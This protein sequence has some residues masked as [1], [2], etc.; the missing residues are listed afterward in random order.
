MTSMNCVVSEGD[1]VML[2][3]NEGR[4]YVV[5]VVRGNILSFNEGIVKVDDLLGKRYGETLYT[6]LGVRF[7]ITKPAILDVVYRKFTRRTQVVYPKD[8]AFI[9]LKTGVGPGSRVVEAGT[10]SGYLTAVLAYFV[11]PDGKVYTYEV[12]GEFLDIARRNLSIAE[13][14]RWVVFKKKDVRQGIDEEEVD[15]VVL[16]MAEPWSALKHA[17]SALRSGG[18]LACFLPTINQVERTV[19]EARELGFAMIEVDEILMRRYKVK[20]GETRPEARMRGH[21]GFL[22]F[23]RK[24]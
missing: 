21:T 4:Y 6:H 18:S 13:L 24:L 3:F 10:G 17:Y 2:C 15:A 9:V 12:R 7:T 5:R 22:V 11:R 23:A 14:D 1:L 16:D 20:R 8:A 19:E